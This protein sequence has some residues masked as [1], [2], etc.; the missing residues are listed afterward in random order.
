MAEPPLVV[1]MGV[2]GSGKSTVGPRLA[3]ELGLPFVDADDMHSDAAKA[4]MAAGRP[5]D[6][7]A[8]R[9]WLDRLH[10]VLVEHRAGG[11]VLACSA[12]KDSYREQLAAGVPGVAFVAL[13]AP[14]QVLEAR[15]AQRP[16]HFAGPT[17]LPSQL[18]DLELG[19][20]TI[21]ID[22]TQ[23]IEAVTTAVASAI[24]NRA[25]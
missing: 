18:L 16:D 13:V 6:D 14:P 22:C 23:P 21:P 2:A 25:E 15:L 9:P 20:D 8:R 19:G 3:R 12:L 7:A 4:E 10:A 1:L 5:L 11:L 24:R 17:L